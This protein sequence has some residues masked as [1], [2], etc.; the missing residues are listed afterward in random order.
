VTT[1]TEP[2][3]A[4]K[5]LGSSPNE[6]PTVA[7]VLAGITAVLWAQAIIRYLTANMT[8]EFWNLIFP[9][10]TADVLAIWLVSIIIGLAVFGAA[11]LL[12]RKIKRVSSVR[13]WIVIL[14]ASAILR[15]L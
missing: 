13:V 9:E 4:V 14:L 8:I 6:S 10:K 15:Y 1:E 2:E 12:F 11:N 3:A 7:S 5:P